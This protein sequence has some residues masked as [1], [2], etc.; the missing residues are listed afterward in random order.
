MTDILGSI[1]TL[2]DNATGTGTVRMHD[3][4]DTSIEDLWSAMTEPDRVARWIGDI[5][6]DL[7]AGGSFTAKL[8]SHWEGAARVDVCEPHTR[9]VVTMRPGGEDE[10]VFEARLA[11]VDGATDL[12]VEERGLP[13]ATISAHGAG[14]QA[15][16]ED[17]AAHIAGRQ[18]VPWEDR[19]NE[20]A[21]AYETL[22]AG[23]RAAR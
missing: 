11:A 14:W 18:P 19:W 20:L 21:P 1:L 4:F 8:T 12:V 23:V 6:G 3:R 13:L 5:H 15:H 17:L 16:L 7:R 2:D 22:A 10:T 9:L